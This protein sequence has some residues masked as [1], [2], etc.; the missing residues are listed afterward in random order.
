MDN[1]LIRTMLHEIVNDYDVSEATNRAISNVTDNADTLK[2]V[3]RRG[4]EDG[5]ID[6]FKI[7][8]RFAEE[9]KG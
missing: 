4:F 5:F 9:L 6:G 7:G 3:V 8:L 1:E 2:T